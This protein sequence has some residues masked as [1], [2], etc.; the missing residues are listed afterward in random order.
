MYFTLGKFFSDRGNYAKSEELFRAAVGRSA[1]M[2]RI[3][4]CYGESL[5]LVKKYE[6]AVSELEKALEED[7]DAPE[8]LYYLGVCMKELGFYGKAKAYFASAIE[9]FAKFP[10]IHCMLGMMAIVE[11]D[12]KK[13]LECFKKASDGDSMLLVEMIG[14]AKAA[15]GAGASKS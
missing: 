15:V 9:K 7:G 2:R 4:Y 6:E 14:K 3:H 13:A 8:T 1:S 12:R 11:G 10:E 5:C